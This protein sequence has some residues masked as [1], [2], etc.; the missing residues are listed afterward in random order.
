MEKVIN[1]SLKLA[2]CNLAFCRTSDNKGYTA[3]G[4]LC[5]MQTGTCPSVAVHKSSESNVL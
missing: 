1:V 4:I 2:T 3:S 5:P